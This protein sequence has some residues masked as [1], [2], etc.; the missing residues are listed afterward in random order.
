[1]N[2]TSGLR[3]AAV[4]TTRYP[5]SI[6]CMIIIIAIIIGRIHGIIVPTKD[7]QYKSRRGQITYNKIRIGVLVATLRSPGTTNNAAVAAICACQRVKGRPEGETS[8]A[9]VWLRS[10]TARVRSAPIFIIFAGNRFIRFLKL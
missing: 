5:C 8:T 1:M 2:Y 3:L 9:R 6:I 7:E 4:Y 10:Q